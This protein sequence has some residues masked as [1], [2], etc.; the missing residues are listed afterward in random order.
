MRYAQWRIP[1]FT[2]WLIF[3]GCLFI[4]ALPILVPLLAFTAFLSLVYYGLT[5]PMV[6]WE[7]I[8]P[9]GMCRPPWT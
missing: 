5:F 8:L 9:D 3:A 2:D 4:G 1:S 6:P 7:A